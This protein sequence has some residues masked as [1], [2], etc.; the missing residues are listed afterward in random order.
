[1]LGD[2]LA[3]GPMRSLLLASLVLFAAAA[4]TAPARSQVVETYTS[5]DDGL[6]SRVLRLGL[7]CT[8]GFDFYER[9]PVE[10]RTIQ[11][12]GF[13]RAVEAGAVPPPAPPVVPVGDPLPW[14]LTD[15][16]SAYRFLY[17]VTD[18][19]SALVP[20][21][22]PA[23]PNGSRVQA[24]VRPVKENSRLL[25][26]N[27]YLSCEQEDGAACLN[28]DGWT[29]EARYFR[30]NRNRN[31][32][33]LLERDVKYSVAAIPVRVRFRRLAVPDA[34]GPE[35]PTT[36]ATGDVSAGLIRSWTLSEREFRYEEG[37]P[38]VLFRTG[39]VRAFSVGVGFSTTEVNALT[40]SRD[41]TRFEAGTKKIQMAVVS[42]MIG[43]G[44]GN[45]TVLINVFAG[46]D[47]GLF[48]GSGSWDYQGSPWV[49][50]GISSGKLFPF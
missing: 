42:P 37:A 20:S 14:A 40:G 32:I 43:V 39:R 50:L 8:E 33:R 9:G 16:T 29:S 27:S 10:R 41:R 4:G 45:G 34:D 21:P 18:S 11:L 46:V 36:Q 17:A 28:E 31:Y 22:F 13:S 35:S 2:P 1:M 38:S 6:R 15:S 48:E 44:F 24:T 7:R 47:V 19:A 5:C 12:N 26:F 49:G 3:T 23:E 30:F 25:L